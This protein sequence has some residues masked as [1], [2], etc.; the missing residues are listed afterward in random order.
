[1]VILKNDILMVWMHILIN[2]DFSLFWLRRYL[3]SIYL[4]F[5][6]KINGGW[7][8]V[9]KRLTIVIKLSHMDFCYLKT[10]S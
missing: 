6:N 1:M 2:N 10:K 3:D 8:F 5:L 7:K 9:L 4:W